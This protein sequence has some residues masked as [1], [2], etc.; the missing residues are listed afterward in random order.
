MNETLQKILLSLNR[1]CRFK[2]GRL[3]YSV[4]LVSVYNPKL[5]GIETRYHL[6]ALQTQ[7]YKNLPTM[8]FANI[9]EM[10]EYMLDA[11]AFWQRR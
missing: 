2:G 4:K 7:P 11:V 1:A 9:N 3:Q 8:Q 6:M 10:K 5:D